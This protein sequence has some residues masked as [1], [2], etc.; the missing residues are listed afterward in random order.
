MKKTVMGVYDSYDDVID[1][2]EALDNAGIPKEVISVLGKGNEKM[3]NRFE[4]YKH[5]QDAA[6]WGEQGAFW[7]AIMGFLAG[8]LLFFLPGFGP[9]IASG[10]IMATLAGMAGGAVLGG[11]GA[12]L[13][14]VLV[15]WGITEAEAKRYEDLLKEGKFI[16]MIHADEEIARKAEEIMKGQTNKEVKLH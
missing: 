15:D 7:G 8:G 2:I 10:P 4:Y 14:A 1:T 6:F 13:I 9:I 12:S 5:S 3:H 11:A 16:V